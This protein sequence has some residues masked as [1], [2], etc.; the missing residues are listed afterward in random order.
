MYLLDII[1]EWPHSSSLLLIFPQM[2]NLISNIVIF[3]L[4]FIK[5]SILKC[6]QKYFFVFENIEIKFLGSDAQIISCPT[7]SLFCMQKRFPCIG[8]GESMKSE[9]CD[10]LPKFIKISKKK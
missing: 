2:L 8:T 10:A 7:K 6:L 9:N 5:L 3:L 1:Y 4:C